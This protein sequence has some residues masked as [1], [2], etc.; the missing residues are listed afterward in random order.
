MGSIYYYYCRRIFV[1]YNEEEKGKKHQHSCSLL[2]C[3][4][5]ESDHL[6]TYRGTPETLVRRKGMGRYLHVLLFHILMAANV[7]D[8]VLFV[9]ILKGCKGGRKDQVHMLCA[10]FLSPSSYS[11]LQQIHQQITSPN[12]LTPNFTGISPH[13]YSY[14]YIHT[15]SHRSHCLYNFYP[16]LFPPL[17]MLKLRTA[18]KLLSLK[19]QLAH[20]AK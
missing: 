8:S 11:K 4:W 12:P 3:P 20:C 5:I 14:T 10:L 18:Q 6:N 7:C 9:I 16:S 19:A 15:P 17:C 1:K 13:V 2:T